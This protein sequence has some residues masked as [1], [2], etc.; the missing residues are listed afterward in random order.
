MDMLEEFKEEWKRTR[1]SIVSDGWTDKKRRSICNFLM[2]SPKG[3]IFIYFIDT[4]SI[5]KTAEK[6]FEILDCIMGKVGEDNIVQVITDNVAN[7]TNA[8]EILMEKGKKLYCASCAV[9]CV[10]LILEDFKKKLRC[11]VKP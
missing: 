2:N 8:R 10:D 3:T 9:H 6:V 1:C 7:Y 4:S 11:I 5:S